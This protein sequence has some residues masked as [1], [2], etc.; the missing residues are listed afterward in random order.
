MKVQIKKNILFLLVVIGMILSSCSKDKSSSQSNKPSITS[1]TSTTISDV[2]TSSNTNQV[3]TNEEV[4]TKKAPLQPQAKAQPKQPLEIQYQVHISPQV[5]L[6]NGIAR[7]N[8][9]KEIQFQFKSD[10]FK[11]VKDQE[12]I[13]VVDRESNDDAIRLSLI[14]KAE[15]NELKNKKTENSF[16]LTKGNSQLLVEVIDFDAA[17]KALK[18]I[19]NESTNKNMKSTIF[20]NRIKLF[21][22]QN[23]PYF[24]TETDAPILHSPGT[25]EFQNKNRAKL[26]SFSKEGIIFFAI[27][28]PR[29][30]VKKQLL[31]VIPS[32][33]LFKNSDPPTQNFKVNVSNTYLEH[34]QIMIEVEIENTAQNGSF[35]TSNPFEY[36]E[37]PCD[38]LKKYQINNSF[39]NRKYRVVHQ[40]I[41]DAKKEE[42][43]IKG[44]LRGS[45]FIFDDMLNNFMLNF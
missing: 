6:N 25:P 19:L 45:L 39:R 23:H 14:S 35:L 18:I 20:G 8:F 5:L 15:A 1:N 26:I 37:A 28:T 13:T 24:F 42:K 7:A 9:N 22:S 38:S 16:I 44:K 43:C 3:T 40:I 10:E 31:D 2:T 30:D 12:N 27:T 29:K 33:R 21:N 32:I 17:E 41:V 34:E 36:I 4:Q 11:L